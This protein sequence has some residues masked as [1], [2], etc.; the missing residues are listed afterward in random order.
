MNVCVC[1]LEGR[2]G[3]NIGGTISQEKTDILGEKLS[4]CQ[5]SLQKVTIYIG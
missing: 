5:F 4:R 3:E 2:G 1:V